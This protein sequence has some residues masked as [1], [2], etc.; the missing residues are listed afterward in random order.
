MN[1]AQSSLKT[2]SFRNMHVWNRK[3]MVDS[4]TQELQKIHKGLLFYFLNDWDQTHVYDTKLACLL[5]GLCLKVD[6]FPYIY[7]FDEDMYS[8]C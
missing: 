1:R 8:C 7:I 6:F 3:K 2:G 4:Q 5:N